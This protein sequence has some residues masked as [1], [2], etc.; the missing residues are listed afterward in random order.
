MVVVDLAGGLHVGVDDDGAHELESS[1]AEV[2]GQGHGLGGL[3]GH[4]LVVSAQGLV[5]RELPDVAVEGAELF[6]DLQEALG[7]VDDGLD[8]AS[9][10]DDARVGHQALDVGFGEGGD[11]VGV[12]AGEGFAEV[13][14]LVEDGLP[15]ESRIACSPGRGTRTA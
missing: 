15:G 7:V 4:L 1:G 10:S 14:P 11:F 2:L 9:V 13:L 6:L 8:L 12:E 3:G 5:A